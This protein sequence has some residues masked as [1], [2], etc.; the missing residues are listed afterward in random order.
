[1]TALS[2][3]CKDPRSK[4][5]LVLSQV[6]L[7]P[8][9]LQEAISGFLAVRA[10]S[11]RSQLWLLYFAMG[12]SRIIHG[13]ANMLLC[14]KM[15]KVVH[16]VI[17]SKGL[18]RRDQQEFADYWVY[19]GNQASIRYHSDISFQVGQGHI[20]L[21]DEADKLIFSDPCKLKKLLDKCPTIC[22]T[23]SCPDAQE[24]SLERR[25][26][27]KLRLDI[28]EYW[29]T[30]IAKPSDARVLKDLDAPT[31][32]DLGAFIID[33]AKQMAVLLYTSRILTDRVKYKV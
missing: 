30:K 16:I 8:N 1:M 31:V 4:S 5:A 15:A 29:P 3:L 7:R 21:I 22:F 13:A 10:E 11:V 23:A 14:S 18:L 24:E 17:P 33:K 2:S 12:K 26:F 28:S 20:V 9:Q 32:D 6:Q 25:I 27:T 19:G